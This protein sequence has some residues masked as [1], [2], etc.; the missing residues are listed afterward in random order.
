MISDRLATAERLGADDRTLAEGHSAYG[1]LLFWNGRTAELVEAG[2][3]ARAHAIRAGD[4]VLEAEA[5]AR[6]GVGVFYGTATWAEAETQAH[7]ALR[8]V[9]RLGQSMLG[10]LQGLAGVAAAR[11]RFDEAR[12]LYREHE[13][14]LEE[15]GLS[16]QL[17]SHGQHRAFGEILA[18]DFE[19]AEAHARRAW[20]GLG[21]LGERGYRSTAGAILAEALV[22]QGRTEEARAILEEADAIT[23]E[24]DWLTIAH[25]NWVRALLALRSGDHDRAAAHART[26]TEVA[27]A[28]EYFNLRT[29][30]WIGRS[31][32]LVETGR[33][34]EAHAAI[35]EAQRLADIKQSPLDQERIRELLDRL[36]VPD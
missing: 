10:G 20:D 34:A 31:R 32:V 24:D 7:A 12:E 21:R 23:A 18:R 17:T 30:Y 28:R 36:A 22:E 4:L 26:A 6:I 33:D 2:R 13:A 1:Q 16:F 35:A 11:G 14:S 3:R 29:Y 27:D 25:C 5:L 8:E 9:D 15:R 19:Q